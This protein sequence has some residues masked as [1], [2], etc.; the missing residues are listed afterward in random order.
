MTLNSS[1]LTKFEERVGIM[2]TF[3]DDIKGHAKGYDLITKDNV[4]IDEVT[5]VS[6]LKHNLHNIS[7]LC[8]KGFII[9]FTLAACVIADR[10]NNNMVLTRDIKGMCT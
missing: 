4:I 8:Y 3:E 9:C 5:L 1:M 2:I 6:S 7:Q 10:V